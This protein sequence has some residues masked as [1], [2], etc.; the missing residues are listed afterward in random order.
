MSVPRTV[1]VLRLALGLALAAVLAAGGPLLAQAHGEEGGHGMMERDGHAMPAGGMHGGHGA[2]LGHVPTAI[3]HQGDLLG[4]TDGQKERLEALKDS[5]ASLR[6]SRG[7]DSDSKH[8]G[9]SSVLTGSGIDVEAYESALRSMADRHIAARVAVARI[10]RRSLQ[11]LDEDQREKFLYGFRL[12]HRIH[13][14]HQGGHG[15]MRDGKERRHHGGE[16]KEREGG[17]R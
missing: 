11:V 9:M 16:M 10:A 17:G 3:L 2:M 1:P 7:G 4:L 14:M 6:E 12:M 8:G 13:R 5:L 15:K